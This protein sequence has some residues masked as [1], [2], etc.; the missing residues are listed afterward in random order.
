MN[1]AGMPM[2][3]SKYSKPDKTQYQTQCLTVSVATELE[4]D[5]GGEYCF[6]F[7]IIYLFIYLFIYLLR[8]IIVRH[9]KLKVYIHGV[10]S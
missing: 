9:L 5:L 2:Y 8:D 6:H 7:F 4:T 1:L 10:K 3:K